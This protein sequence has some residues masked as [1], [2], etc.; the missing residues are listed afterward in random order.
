MGP[1][2][3]EPSSTSGPARPPSEPACDAYQPPE[4]AWEEEF[5]PMADSICEIN[6][7]D[8]SCQ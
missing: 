5:A 3:Q 7:L 6:P 8:P 1:K 4:I 2:D